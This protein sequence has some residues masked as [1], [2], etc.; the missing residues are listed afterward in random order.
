MPKTRI[1]CPNCRQPIMAEIDQLFDVSSDPSVKARFLS[2]AFNFAQCPQCGF[3]GMIATPLVYH[4]NEKDLLILYFPPELALPVNEQERMVG[5]IINKITNSLP[6]EKR[7]GYLLRPL[8]MFTLQSMV[9]RI[10]E[11]DGITKEMLQVQQQR[12]SLVQRLANATDEQI[13]EYVTQEDAQLDA[14]FFNLLNR[15]IEAAVASGDQQSGRRLHELQKKLLPITT[16]GREVQAQTQEVEAAVKT[17]QQAGKELTREKLLEIVIKAPN[18]TQLSVITSLA[19]P[20]MDYEFFRMLS[21]RIERAR[22]DGRARLITLREQLLEMTSAIDKQVEARQLHARQLLN[23]VLQAVNIKETLTQN[24]P[25][26]DEFFIHALQEEMEATRKRGDLERIGKLKQVEEVIAEASAPPPEVA[27]IEELLDV[28]GDDASLNKLLEER[29]TAL[30]PE[31]IEVLTSLV[32]RTQ[33][34]S[35]PELHQRMQAVYSAVL[36]LSMR[37]NL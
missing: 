7:K 1:N 6:Q 31:F 10:L 29:K 33:E 11:A 19:R 4:D 34:A 28:A 17:L 14:D 30:T 21:E 18:E 13:K 2:G 37:S 27:F 23:T 16:F 3:Q 32:A 9:E 24:L 20:G 26:V 22:G 8:T 25:A 5:P 12:M 36:R 35:D 15:L